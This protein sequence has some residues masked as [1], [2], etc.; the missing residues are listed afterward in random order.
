MT[1]L[2]GLEEI[3]GRPEGAG[4]ATRFAVDPSLRVGV[5]IP[6]LNESKNLR[7]VLPRIPAWIDQVVIVDGRSS[8]DTVE[9]ALRLVPGAKVVLETRPGKGRALI[10]G[11]HACDA[12]LIVTF[13]ADGSMDPGE[14]PSFVLPLLLGA[15]FVK[16][17]RFLQSAG[18]HDMGPLRRMGNWGLKSVVRATFGGRF[19]D[20]CYGYNAFWKDILPVFEGDAAGFEIET[21]MNVR[22][23][24]HGLRIV[25]VPSF[26]HA[27]IHGESNLRTFRDGARVLRT[28]LTERSRCSRELRAGGPADNRPAPAGAFAPATGEQLAEAVPSADY[29]A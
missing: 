9:E 25:E 19:T 5:V 3:M 21:F 27:R 1:L 17:S 10:T 20:L 12:D 18:T 16:G 14:I 15:D 22:A 11:F 23:L 7:H 8:D 28:I 24:A 29:A 6:T 4:H 13:D 2:R 26:E